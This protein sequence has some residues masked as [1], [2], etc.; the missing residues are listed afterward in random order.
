MKRMTL[1]IGLF[2]ISTTSFTLIYGLFGLPLEAILYAISLGVFLGAIILLS[3]AFLYYKNTQSLDQFKGEADKLSFLTQKLP[4]PLDH[5]E[6]QYQEILLDLVEMQQKNWT[7]SDH[8]FKELRDY[9]TLWVH[10]IKTPISALGL[11]F[12]TEADTEKSRAMK[13]ELFKIE[14]Y[15]EMVLHMM[16]IEDGDA[17]LRLSAC[18]LESL[19]HGAVKKYRSLFI[20]KKIKLSLSLTPTTVLSDEKWA[21]VILEQLISNGLKYTPKGEIKIYNSEAT[22][23]ILTIEDTGIGIHEED[24]PRVFEKGFTGYNGR[25][26]KKATGIGLYLTQKICDRLGIQIEMR[27]GV[28][29]GTKVNLIFIPY[30]HVSLE[31]KM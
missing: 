20:E 16:R 18:D 27:S 26:D 5:L 1:G 9:Y 21:V 31:M 15:V 13:L 22:P 14:Q 3:Y 10:Q 17:D 28:D 8:K 30:N 11:M 7:E 4:Q 25:L 2:L 19:C 6:A 12:Q 24:L 29:Q 23:H